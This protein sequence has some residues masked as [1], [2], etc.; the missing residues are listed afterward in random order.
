MINI[1]KSHHY[2][3]QMHADGFTD[4][5]GMLWAFT[6]KTGK[7]FRAT[8]KAVFTEIQEQE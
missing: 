5:D 2:V 7:L 1:P 8:P 3:A 4:A 6:K